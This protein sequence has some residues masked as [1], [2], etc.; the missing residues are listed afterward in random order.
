MAH[1][2]DTYFAVE[3]SAGTTLRDL[4]TYLTSCDVS[5]GNDTH[6]DT[7]FGKDGHTWRGGLTNGT[8]TING[9][10]DKTATT[11]PDAVLKSLVGHEVPVAWEYGAEGDTAGLPK[12]SGECVLSSYDT[13][14]PVAD[15]VSFSASFNISGPIVDGVFP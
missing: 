9:L 6:D 5:R 15:L 4:S 1:G 12:E 14:A 11:G 2:K 13:S 3:D 7:T 10:Y 8:I